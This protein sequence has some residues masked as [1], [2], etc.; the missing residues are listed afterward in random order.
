MGFVAVFTLGES[1]M[2]LGFLCAKWI[3]SVH[4]VFEHGWAM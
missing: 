3:S 4:G 2:I 1:N